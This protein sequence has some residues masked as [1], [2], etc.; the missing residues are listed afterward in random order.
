MYLVQNPKTHGWGPVTWILHRVLCKQLPNKVI[1]LSLL[2]L[3][4][5]AVWCLVSQPC[6]TLCYPMNHSTPGFQSPTIPQ[7]LLRL[8]SIESV[9]SSNHL[10]LCHPLLLLPSIAPASGSFPISWLFTSGDRGIKL[11]FQHQSFQWIFRV[12]S[13]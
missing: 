10:I 5:C 8:M 13:L 3:L 4:S 12:D 11:Q 2:S 7:S 1:T 9:M 6:L